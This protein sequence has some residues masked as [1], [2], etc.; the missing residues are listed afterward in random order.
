M[1]GQ[2]LPICKYTTDMDI[3]KIMT[4]TLSVWVI[5]THVQA[6]TRPLKHSPVHVGLIYPLSTNGRQAAAYSN[7]F[8]LHAIAGVSGEETGIALAGFALVVKDS[9]K[10]LLASGFMNSTG[11]SQGVNMAGFINVSGNAG[12]QIGGF[13]NMAKDVKGVQAAGFI[14]IARK[15]SGVQIAGFINIADSSDYP[16]ALIN[17]IRHGEKSIG[18]STDETFTSLV[19]FRSGGRKL[20]GI[21]GAGYNGRDNKDLYAWE[22]GIGAHFNIVNNFRLNMELVSMGL[23]DFR[24]GDYFRSTLRL[25][26]ALRLGHRVELFAGPSFNY[27]RSEK[28]RDA[29]LVSHYLWSEKESSGLLHGLWFGAT[30]GMNIIL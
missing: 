1:T 25:L 23:T 14:N 13:M 15:V 30:G 3:L 9:A 4:F 11:S 6:Q 21:V 5:C 2:L 29:G 28:G 19:T 12:T 24:S 8:S 10:G 7:G 22:G 20:Y 27:L 26:P 16:I 17:I 18:V